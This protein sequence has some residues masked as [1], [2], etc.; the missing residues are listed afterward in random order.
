[1]TKQL[2][3][4]FLL[5][6]IL[7]GLYIYI[8]ITFKLYKLVLHPQISIGIFLILAGFTQLLGKLKLYLAYLFIATGIF[9]L[10]LY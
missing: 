10:I 6:S 7:L 5:L 8:G 3:L 9:L 1:M 4:I 2:F